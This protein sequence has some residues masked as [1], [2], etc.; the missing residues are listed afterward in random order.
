MARLPGALLALFLTGAGLSQ[1]DRAVVFVDGRGDDLITIHGKGRWIQDTGRVRV[2][3]A[4]LRIERT[5]TEKYPGFSASNVPARGAEA[6]VLGIFLEGDQPRS[7]RVRLDDDQSTDDKDDVAIEY[8]TI[9]PGWNDV[10]VSLKDRKTAKERLM[11]FPTRVRKLQFTKKNEEGDPAI[12]LDSISVRGAPPPAR[13]R[14]AFRDAFLEEKD[15]SRKTKMLKEVGALPDADIAAVTLE[16]L[17]REP[18][19]RLRRIAREELSR[20]SAAEVALT[21]ADG[22]KEFPMPERLEVLWAVAAMPCAQTRQRALGWARDSKMPGTERTAAITGLRLAGGADVRLLAADLPPAAAWPMRAALVAGIRAVAEPE[23]VDALIAVL[24]EPGSA[25]VAEDAEAA[26]R[27]LTGADYGPDA[28]TWRDWWRVNRDKVALGAKPKDRP[29]SYGKSTFYGLE[30]PQGRIAFVIDTSRSMADPVGEG[31][32]TDYMKRSGHLSPTAIRSRLDLAIAELSH[33][34]M[35]MKDRSHV[36]VISFSAAEFWVT[37]GFETINQE[38]RA[39]IGEKIHRLAAGQ[40]TNLYAGMYAAF[41]PEGKP[42][43]Q[44]LTEGPDT[45]FVLTD[46][47][48]SSG[49]Y[50]DVNDLRD[51]ILAWNLGRAIKIHCVNVGE[52][53]ARL[54]TSL[55][56]GT[57]G[58]VVDLSSDKKAPERPK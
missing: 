45:I 30:V 11:S 54:L 48:P 39:K 19:P 12:V 36:G 5:A 33:A 17:K 14:R 44:D 7:Y 28:A 56:V 49:K 50:E 41:H 57:G 43:P 40:S 58:V 15:L 8:Q 51:E 6:L 42:R 22:C 29:A 18:Q 37:K 24:A 38:Q 52:V 3:V 13:D 31:R 34:V 16:I 26:L 2:G 25:R 46:G 4:A 20:V 21:V 53:D 1:G 47:N 27:A 35:N 32:V 55:A 23:S 9:Q 10:V